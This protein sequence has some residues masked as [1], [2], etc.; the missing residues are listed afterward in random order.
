MSNII[1][2]GLSPSTPMRVAYIQALAGLTVPVFDTVIPKDMTPIPLLYILL[3][4]FTK[5]INEDCKDEVGW[6]CTIILDIISVQPSGYADREVVDNVEAQVINLI[7]LL[8]QFSIPGFEVEYTRYANSVSLDVIQPPA[9]GVDNI[10][11][12]AITYEHLIYQS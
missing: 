6:A 4:D 8:N 3:H 5:G 7:R 10:I 12:T 2:P 1:Q 11:R 9:S